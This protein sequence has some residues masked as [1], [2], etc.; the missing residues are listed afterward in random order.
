MS[1]ISKGEGH[2]KKF[3]QSLRE[4]RFS[5]TGWADDQNIAFLEFDIVDILFLRGD[6]FVVVVHGNREDSFG[7]ILANDILVE[8]M[9]DFSRLLELRRDFFPS[10]LPNP[11]R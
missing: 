6:A 8:V 10:P 9:F 7:A 1:V 3:G 4:E 5:G 2:V 11:L